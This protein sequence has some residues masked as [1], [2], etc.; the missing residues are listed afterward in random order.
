MYRSVVVREFG[1]PEKLV[2]EERSSTSLLQDQLRVKINSI[3]VNRADILLRKGKYHEKNLPITPGFE[4]AG[5][6]IESKGTIK[7]GTCVLIFNRK[8]GLYTEEAVVSESDVV[9]VPRGMDDLTAASLPINWLSAY[10]MLVRRL[11]MQKGESLFVNAGASGVGQAVIQIGKKL[12][13]HVVASV[14]GEQ[15]AQYLKSNYSCD[16]IVANYEDVVEK[17]LAANNN[18]L[19]E[20]SF[21]IVGGKMFGPCLKLVGDFGRIGQAANV[22]T[23]D[24]L[25]NVRDFYPKNKTIFGFQY[26]NSLPKQHKQMAADLQKLLMDFV[27]GHYRATISKTFRLENASIAHE[28]LENEDHYGKI[29]LTTGTS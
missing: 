26:G 17:A 25:I 27:E 3:G 22:T 6:V 19:F 11:Q 23:E 15:K 8:V 21:D 28:A 5:E 10:T 13:V 29:M 18:Q 9:T 1:G 20:A 24:S 12:G 4:A 16:V 7:V 14:R 2:I